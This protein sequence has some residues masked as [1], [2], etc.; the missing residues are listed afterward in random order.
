[1]FALS[2]YKHVKGKLFKLLDNISFQTLYL[3]TNNVGKEG[4]K[5]QHAKAIIRHMNERMWN[6]RAITTTDDRSPRIVFE[7]IK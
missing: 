2:L 1:M 5:S 6:W 3:E 4:I 7:V